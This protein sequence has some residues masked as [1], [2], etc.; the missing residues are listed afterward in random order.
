MK[1]KK[2]I[3]KSAAPI[4]ILALLSGASATEAQLSLEQQ[5]LMKLY[6]E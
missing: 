6:E 3:M 5:A 1:Y 4:V 2:L